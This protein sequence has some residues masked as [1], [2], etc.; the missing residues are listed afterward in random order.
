MNSSDEDKPSLS[1]RR[2][3]SSGFMAAAGA[4]LST[5][6]VLAAVTPTTKSDEPNLDA[7]EPFWSEHQGG[8]LT[9]L[10]RNTYFVAFDLITTER[11]DIVKMLQVW[12]TAAANMTAGQTAEPLVQD[13]SVPAPDSGETL[14][15]PSARLTLTFGF[16]AG[17]FIKDGK[18]RYGL[19]AHRPRC[20]S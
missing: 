12:T 8:I 4:G 17:L 9:P 5:Q 13:G 15:L 10:Q 16:G 19:V 18:D 20:P 2:F 1:R 7:T 3:L 6:G 11:T 14:G